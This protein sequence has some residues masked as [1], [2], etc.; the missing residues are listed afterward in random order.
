MFVI[1]CLVLPS[2]VKLSHVLQHDHNHVVCIEKNQVHFHNIEYDCEFYKFNVN[3]NLIFEHFNYDVNK[4]SE[5]NTSEIA[6]YA[7]LKSH[8]QLSSFLRGPPQHLV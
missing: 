5:T 1:A 7:F 8:Q 3:H 4:S 2:M 6:Y